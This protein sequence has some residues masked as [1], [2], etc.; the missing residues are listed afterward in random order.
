MVQMDFES[1]AYPIFRWVNEE[2]EARSIF[3]GKERKKYVKLGG[4]E[5]KE[6]ARKRRGGAG[7][8]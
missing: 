5:C 2:E 1:K 4:S 6:A 8:G 7:G 3:D